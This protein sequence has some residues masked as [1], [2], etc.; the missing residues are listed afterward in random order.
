MVL[1]GT[2]P[3][4]GAHGIAI[5]GNRA[6]ITTIPT[7]SATL[8]DAFEVWNVG[9]ALDDS[10]A[11]LLTETAP[12]SRLPLPSRPQN[13]VVYGGYAFVINDML[14]ANARTWSID[15]GNPT[16]PR[17]ASVAIAA[18]TSGS[19]SGLN[20]GAIQRGSVQVAGSHLYLGGSSATYVLELE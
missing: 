14:G 16:S 8:V 7:G 19:C 11:T 1:Q 18:P 2:L 13:L 15:I 20:F 3:I 10:A 9:A 12:I 5:S 6:F 17:I 4:T